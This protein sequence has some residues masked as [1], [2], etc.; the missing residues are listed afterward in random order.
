MRA[1]VLTQTNQ[2]SIPIIYGYM[3]SDFPNKTGVLSAEME[4]VENGY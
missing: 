4:W 1:P 2:E 3:D